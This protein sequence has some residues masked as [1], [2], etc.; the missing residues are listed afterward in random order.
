MVLKNSS[1]TNLR[2]ELENRL[3][4]GLSCEWETAVCFLE[5][6]ISKKMNQPLFSLKSTGQKLAY[7]DAAKREICFNSDFVLN[8]PW[9]SVKEVLLHEMAHQLTSEVFKIHNEHPHGKSFKQACLLLRANPKAS[10]SYAPLSERIKNPAADENDKIMFRVKKL[11]ALAGSN[12]IHEAEAAVA[13]AHELIKK[14]NIDILINDSKRDFV[15]I[16]V[17]RPSLRHFRD[18]YALANLL[19]KH[20]FVYG[21]WISSYVVEKGKMG[22]VLEI[23]GTVQNIKIASYVYDFINNYIN[24]SWSL[25]NKNNHHNRYRKTDFATGLIEGFD[26]KL[27]QQTKQNTS[28][29]QCLSNNTPLVIEDSKLKKYTS[30]RYPNIRNFK[31]GSS[32]IDDK[33]KN[34]GKKIG[35]K[36]VISKG[37]EKNEGGK[38]EYLPNK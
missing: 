21:I 23:S 28:T 5:P 37:I 24:S 8:H 33:V 22:R 2:T 17:G 15:S 18:E 7:W 25:Y 6:S 4:H 11:L 1:Q 29:V 16:C 26:A 20:Y 12:H 38:V 19:T 30:Y 14:Y 32:H 35:R 34:D 27:S 36:L 13:K 9:D 3:L 10:G 31:R